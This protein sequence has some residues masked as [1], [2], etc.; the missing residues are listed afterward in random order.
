MVANIEFLYICRTLKHAR[1]AKLVDAPSSG[2]GAARCDGSNPFLGTKK[3]NLL[4]IALFSFLH[5]PI[6]TY[7]ANKASM[8]FGIS[9]GLNIFSIYKK[10]LI[11][12]TTML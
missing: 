6:Q 2:G 10:K 11:L 4:K 5:Y 7:T 1:V 3:G 9:F 12:L 8:P